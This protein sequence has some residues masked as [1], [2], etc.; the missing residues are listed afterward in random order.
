MK[1]RLRKILRMMIGFALL[2]LGTMISK[3]AGGLNPWNVLNDGM[4]HVLPITIGRANQI[5]GVIIICIDILARE[6][7]GIGTVLNAIFIGTFSDLFLNLNAKLGLVP[8]VTSLPLQLPLWLLAG[9]ISGF[10]IYYYMSAE[11]GSGPRDSL[12]LAVT[13]R[14]PFQVGM[15]RMALEAMAFLVGAL[16]GGEFSIGT[17]IS[18]A[19]GGPILQTICKLTGFDVKKIHNESFAET[20][21]FLKG[22]MKDRKNA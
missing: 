15:C 16:L 19:I 5:V 4:T 13:R 8:K 2:G 11:M 12:M 21:A 20:W 9:V 17:F 22:W 6:H 7:L 3:Q 10:G 18:V 14:V 1:V